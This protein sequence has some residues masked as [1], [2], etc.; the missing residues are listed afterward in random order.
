[1]SDQKKI[2]KAIDAAIK[3]FNKNIPAAQKDML[4]AIQEELKALDINSDGSIKSTV[5]NIGLIA[6]ISRKMQSIIV[7]DDY[8]EEVKQFAKTFNEVTTLQNQY[9]KSVEKQYRPPNILAEIR[10]MTIEDTVAKLMEAGIGVNVGDRIADLLKANITTGGSYKELSKVLTETLTDTKSGSGAL[11]RYAKQVTT[12][13][14][15]QYNRTYTQTV[16]SDLGFEWYY[17]AN[18]EIQTSRPFCQSMV[19]ENT[20]FHVS[21]VPDMLKA[22]DMYYTDNRDGK[23]KPVPINK[24]TNLPDG[25][26]PGTNPSNFFVYL[27]GYSCGHQANPVS[28]AIVPADVVAKVKASV[29]YK[30]WKGL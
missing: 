29:A 8:R 17:Y 30:R 21:Q 11:T 9:W 18:S 27:G 10:K 5:K 24:K 16:S 13:S 19:E 6:R 4:A 1:M 2:L 20:Y 22:K 12:D 26:I 14:I 23:R 28:E 7:T 25:F 3:R 15:H